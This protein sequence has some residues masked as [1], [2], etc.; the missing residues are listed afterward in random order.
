MS[1]ISRQEWT[2]ESTEDGQR[3]DQAVAAHLKTISRTRIQKLIA[4]GDITLNAATYPASH[5]VRAGDSICAVE[6]EPKTI[7]PQPESIELDVLY[8]DD[9]LLVI[10]KPAGMAVH[11]G[12]GIETGT[13]VN[14]LLGRPHAISS[15][16]GYLRPGIVHRLDKDT[17]GLLI[18]A[19][20]DQ[21]HVTLSQT[22]ADRKI[23]RRYV[24][25]ALR[26]FEEDQGTIDA[27]LGRNA[28]NRLKMMVREG[29]D[30]KEA[31]THWR[32]LERFGGIAQIECKLDTGRTHQIRVH[33]AHIGHPIL[34]DVTYGG[35]TELAT[36]L[37]S[38]HDTRLRATLKTA[39]RQMLHA[40]RLKFDHPR[41]GE[42]MSFSMDP[43]ADYQAILEQLRK[44]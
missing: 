38:P 9:D 21:A 33:M 13:L 17:T 11:P 16:G 1:E 30:V 28:R 26:K 25:L 19:K 39:E 5:T 18:V 32:V 44:S 4:A 34:G 12:R 42:T 8:E 6:P 15:I 2:V 40:H 36:Q 41:T 24:A 29:H 35:S 22:L 10:N 3:L 43:P 14:A 37:I 23:S 27:P 7:A 31:K 20:N